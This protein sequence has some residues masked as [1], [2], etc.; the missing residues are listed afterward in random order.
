MPTPSTL[1]GLPVAEDVR[2]LASDLYLAAYL[3]GKGTRLHSIRF[4]EASRATLVL[5][6]PDALHHR[7][8]YAAGNVCVSLPAFR[9]TLNTLR[10]LV[11]GLQQRHSPR[12]QT[13]P[14]PRLSIP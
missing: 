7:K 4:D 1:T 3:L 9:S 8:A 13:F 10:D 12:N 11:H 5:V 14:A 2:V 6:G